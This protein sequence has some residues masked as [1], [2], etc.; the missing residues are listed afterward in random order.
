M[1][2]WEQPIRSMATL[3]LTNTSVC[4]CER[5]SSSLEGV[6][7]LHRERKNCLTSGRCIDINNLQNRNYKLKST[8]DA[9][10]TLNWWWPFGPT[11]FVEEVNKVW[12]HGSNIFPNVFKTTLS[13]CDYL[14]SIYPEE[15]GWS[16]C[17]VLK[18]E[19]YPG[20]HSRLVRLETKERGV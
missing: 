19:R 8:R 7:R 12:P 2:P 15:L 5:I 6:L 1:R 3:H 18:Q 13:V 11:L 9:I 14:W 17:N 10:V 16:C 4:W 20:I